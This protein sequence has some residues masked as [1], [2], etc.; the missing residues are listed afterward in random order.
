VNKRQKMQVASIERG[1]IAL[2]RLPDLPELAEVRRLRDELAVRSERLI[3]VLAK[4]LRARGGRQVTSKTIDNAKRTL[5]R[6]HLIRISRKARRLFRH[7]ADVLKA[8]R[9]PAS[10]D[11]PQEHA[12][13]AQAMAKALRPHVTFCLTEGFQHGFLSELQEA[14]KQLA[15]M[16]KQSDSA[17][18]EYSRAT[19]HLAQEVRD[20][21]ETAAELDAELHALFVPGE[22]RTREL[23]SLRTTVTMWER[24]IKVRKLVGRPPK[25]RG[26]QA[27]KPA[28][29]S[30]AT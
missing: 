20:A 26:T 29:S 28:S 25:K 3:E 23:D 1:V 24:A 15:K 21:R 8:L 2:Y 14:G 11:T 17:R 18:A 12:K 22:L 30:G 10:R 13:A 27:S 16:A 6:R 19:R 9:V 5:R 4:Q 7:D